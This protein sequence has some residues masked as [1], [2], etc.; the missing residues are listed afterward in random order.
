MEEGAGD[1]DSRWWKA[2]QQG[3][4]SVRRQISTVGENIILGEDRVAER[5]RTLT[6]IPLTFSSVPPS[7]LS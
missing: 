3:E 6:H 2:G 4:Q 1:E 5:V 7:I